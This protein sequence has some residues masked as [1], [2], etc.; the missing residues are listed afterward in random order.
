MRQQS[1]LADTAGIPMPGPDNTARVVDVHERLCR[2]YGCPARYFHDIDPLSE[3]ISAMLSHRTRNQD[4]AHAFRQLRERFPNWE[5][6]RDAP[7]ADVQDAI[8]A[9]T[10]PEQ[11]APRLQ[12][13]LREIAARCNGELS[14]DFLR[15]WPVERARQWLERLPGVG[16]KTSAAVISF[17]TIR[18]KALPVDSHHFRVAARIGLIP[19]G[20]AVGPSH[21]ILEAQLPA[22]WDAQQV[23]D[24]HQVIMKHGKK[25]CTHQ[26]PRCGACVVLDLCDYGQDRMGAPVGP[27]NTMD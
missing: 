8:A 25:I 7:V 1:L 10:W 2:E 12:S 17:S 4:S 6:V 19:S 27:E 15:D 20:M 9:C 22:E 3:L 21:R 26:Q 16:P 24:N 18:G 5:S 13:V 14:L 11:K 23:Y